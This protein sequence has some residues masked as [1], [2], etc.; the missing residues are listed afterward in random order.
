M[1]IR[2]VMLLILSLNLLISCNK[3]K[4]KQPKEIKKADSLFNSKNYE[5]AKGIYNRYYESNPNND[6]VK[7]QIKVVDSLLNLDRKNAQ[8]KEIIKIADSL[9]NNN[10]FSEAE[11]V[12]QEASIVFPLE[13]YP[14][15]Q[16]SFIQNIQ[17]NQTEL[18]DKPYHI[19]LGSFKV[20]ENAAR[21]QK[22]LEDEGFN[23]QF[24][25]RKNGTMKA[26]TYTSHPD[27]HDAWNNLKDVQNNVHEDAWVLYYI[28]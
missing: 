2:N 26:V 28:F 22:K 10:L 25:P 19:I 23:S 13:N 21:L 4:V 12:Y 3:T 9:F 5:K 18:A 24:V 17:N 27:I 16:I 14:I 6:Y 20:E 15:D 8:Y 7:K 11:Y 1:N